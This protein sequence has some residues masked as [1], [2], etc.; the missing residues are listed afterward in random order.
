M[1]RRAFIAGLAGAA[2]WPVVARAQQQPV[3]G[4][5]YVGTREE[6]SLPSFRMGLRETGF[7]EGQNLTIE[8]RYAEDQYERL[9]ALA[10]ELVRRRVAVIYA[11]G[12]FYAISAAKAATATIP[13]VFVTGGD[14]VEP[15]FVA[16]L[17]R[18]S[19]NVTGISFMN[20]QL[21]AKRLG[22]LHDL[23]PSAAR[24]AMLVNPNG[25]LSIPK[26]TI[27]ARAA[28]A[29]IRR[30]IEVFTAGNN[31]EIKSAFANMMQWRA[32]ALLIGNQTLFGGRGARQLAIL[33]ARYTLPAIHFQREFAEVGGLMSYGSN[34][35][36]IGR[37]AGIYVGR[38][39]TGEKPADMPVVQPTKF[40]LVINLT[41][42]K[43]IDLTIPETLLATA[44]EVI[45]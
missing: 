5:L 39:L 7:V 25:Q 19:G 30:D 22:L 4:F 12:G 26:E 21:T 15:G 31:D 23:V 17:N 41:T 40:E 27:D 20:A 18:P 36:E 29:T 38:I 13:I 10:A 6:A 33:T 42:A 14:P 2:A 37:Q 1:K 24:F 11:T 16:S 34:F 8:Y 44:D 28:V 35:N 3:I 32:E 9:P 45:Q 43:A